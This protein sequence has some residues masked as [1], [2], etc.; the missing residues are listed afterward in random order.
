M[1]LHGILWFLG[2]TEHLPGIFSLLTYFRPYS[3]YQVHVAAC[4][5]S[6]QLLMTFPSLCCHDF[7]GTRAFRWPSY[8][9]CDSLDQF[10]TSAALW[11]IERIQRCDA[12]DVLLFIYVGQFGRV[13]DPYSS[14]QV[15]LESQPLPPPPR[16]LTSQ[17]PGLAWPHP[18]PITSNRGCGWIQHLPAI[19]TNR[20]RHC[21]LHSHTAHHALY[22]EHF[23]NLTSGCVARRL[24]DSFLSYHIGYAI[25]DIGFPGHKRIRA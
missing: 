6:A 21:W 10:C 22:G 12:V 9:A 2:W 1:I 5:D 4:V 25:F 14:G 3:H 11:M 7:K 20:N 24:S 18:R 8:S 19:R 13:G 23:A 17:P 16:H 15:L